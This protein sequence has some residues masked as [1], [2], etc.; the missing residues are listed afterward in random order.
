MPKQKLLLYNGVKTMDLYNGDRGWDILSGPG[1]ETQRTPTTQDLF[2]AVP[3]L[4]R[5][6]KDRAT[7]LKKV[8][9]AIVNDQG[10]DLD[11]SATWQDELDLFPYPRRMLH[12]IE[13]SLV[14]TGRAYLFLETNNYGYVTAV[15]YCL[16][17]SIREKYNDN[18]ELLF[19]ERSLPRGVKVQ[20][21][22]LNIVAIYDPDYTVEQGPGQSSAAK[23]ALLAANVLFN[24]DL[25][26]AHYFGRGAIKATI[27]S[28][29]TA[30][31]REAN[32]LQAWWEDVISG[33][34]NAWAA[35]VIRAKMATPTIIGQGLEGLENDSL[36]KSKRQDIS[37]AI[38]VPESRLWAASAN[39]ATAEVEG[40]A[41]YNDVIVPE[42]W[43]IEEALNAQLFTE[44]HHMA[45]YRWEFRPEMGSG[46][47]KDQ[48][49]QST[50]YVDYVGAGML[51]S[52]AAQLVGLELP[53]EMEFADLDPVEKPP[54]PPPQII[55]TNPT[56]PALG[57]GTLPPEKGP[58]G[59][60]GGM[61]S[62]ADFHELEIWQRKCI[63]AMNAGKSPLLSGFASMT[64]PPE[65]VRVISDELTSCK[66]VVEIKDLFARYTGKIRSFG[67]DD[68]GPLLLLYTEL[69]RANDL[70][71]ANEQTA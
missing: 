19:Y 21:E 63:K 35:L 14:M 7:T 53:G 18:G 4:Y 11:N 51:P 41:Y 59:D 10:N 25:F 3:W 20:V 42:C 64:L 49:A 55:V 1:S 66:S 43:T 47:G 38:G 65:I 61:M 28:V 9:F 26:I 16:P 70:V 54:P 57:P 8:A 62:F 44:E 68:S 50:A 31:S 23:A 52:I 17:T 37:T 24:A 40:K 15:K 56:T 58:A 67:T 45:G 46:F 36:T 30:D 33:I 13:E 6:V 71:E 22:P 69:K 12:Q 34:R 39:F 48:Q 32:R 5:A 27:L 29:D 2:I 60:G